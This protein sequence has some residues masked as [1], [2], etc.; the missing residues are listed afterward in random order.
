MQKYNLSVLPRQ[1]ASLVLLTV[2]PLFLAMAAILWNRASLVGVAIILAVGLLVLG[3]IASVVMRH[4]VEV[5]GNALVVKH[6]MYT[7]RVER[8][9]L[10]AVQHIT[11]PEQ[12]GLSTKKNGIAAFGYYSGWF[13]GTRNETIFCAVSTLPADVLS[14]EGHPKCQRLAISSNP[15]VAAWAAEKAYSPAE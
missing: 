9:A 15:L 10:R 4:S 2:G 11:S 7:L 1:I 5:S 14:L 13:S 3:M 6:S 12:L 8:S